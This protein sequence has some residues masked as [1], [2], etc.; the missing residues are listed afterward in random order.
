MRLASFKSA[1]MDAIKYWM[2]YLAGIQ[3]KLLWGFL[4]RQWAHSTGSHPV[5]KLCEDIRWCLPASPP[6]NNGV[7]FSH[8]DMLAA[9][10]RTMETGVQSGD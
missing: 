9:E 1:G 10:S 8:T 7:P 6:P 3:K 2:H 5:A 4:C